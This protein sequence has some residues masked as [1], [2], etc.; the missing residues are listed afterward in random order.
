VAFEKQL[1]QNLGRGWI[2]VDP[3]SKQLHRI[4]AAW[5]DAIQVPAGAVGEKL[6]QKGDQ[7]KRLNDQAV[8]STAKSYKGSAG[9]LKRALGVP[10]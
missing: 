1:G 4:R 7:A 10:Q 8:E 2:Y 9:D 6:I 5:V 3:I